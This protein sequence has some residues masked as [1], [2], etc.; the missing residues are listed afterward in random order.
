M[1]TI[2]GK[3]VCGGYAFGNIAFY[4][5]TQRTVKRSHI[6]DT[7]Q[8]LLRFGQAQQTALAQLRE[9]YE[10]AITDVG[11]ANAQIFEIHQMMLEDEDYLDSITNIITTQLINAEYAVA[12]TADNFAKMFSAMDDDYMR[13]RAADV[14]DISE[15][16]IRVLTGTAESAVDTQT[17]V[18]LAADDLAPSE[19]VQLDKNLILS[20]ITQNGSANSHTAILARMMDI[21]AIV[22][23]KDTLTE[24][25]DGKYA[26]VDG[27][28][29]T[30]YI[31][32]DAQTLQVLREKAAAEA[33]NARRLTQLKGKENRTLDG[34][35]IDLYANIGDVS[36]VAHALQND[37]G[38]IGLFRSEFLY[39]RADNYPTEEEQFQAYKTVA[40]TMAGR[41]VIIRTLDIGADKQIGYFGL[42]P[43]ENP[44]MGFRAIRI[45][46]ERRNIFCT[47][48][49]AI[50]RASAYGTI[51]IMFPMIT[52][53]E[54]VREIKSIIAQVQQ[55]LMEQRVPF[56]DNVELGIMIETPASVMISDLLAKEVDFFSIGTNDLTQYLLAVDRQNQKLDRYYNPYHPALLRCL[57]MAA[58]NAHQEG[59]WIGICGELAGDTALTEMFLAIGIDE[60]SVSPSRILAVREKVRSIQ[61]ENSRA[62]ILSA[63]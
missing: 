43:E 61:L 32:P 12:T 13:E 55:E 33:E 60:L 24:D 6:T 63:F 30:V 47:Q 37:A 57:K 56:S 19:T 51:A 52:A 35:T 9:L 23:L 39:L 45:C 2:T 42:E 22:G 44:A 3:G 18:I 17:P 29:G 62:T 58:D 11:Q 14:R 53:V 25:L 10:R 27:F 8:E 31:D 1:K 16:V 48:L 34:H 7:N 26:V 20:F 36:D 46:L 5:R 59:K 49:R 50:Y 41:K 54:E 4:R 28:T 40:E 21:P 15:R 38:G